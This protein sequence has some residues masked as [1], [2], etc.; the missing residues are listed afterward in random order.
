M[1]S[2]DIKDKLLEAV[3]TSGHVDVLIN[4]AGMTHTDTLIDT[5]MEKYEVGCQSF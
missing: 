4:C 2:R 5:P 1:S 3:S